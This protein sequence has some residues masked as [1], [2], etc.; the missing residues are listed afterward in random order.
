MGCSIGTAAYR[1]RCGQEQPE[2]GGS[3]QR[4]ILLVIMLMVCRPETDAEPERR[5]GTW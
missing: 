3:Y 4:L 2:T 1:N 5:Q